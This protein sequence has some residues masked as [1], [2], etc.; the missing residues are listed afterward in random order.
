MKVKKL[1]TEL[2]KHKQEADVAFIDEESSP[3]PI[4]EVKAYGDKLVV[5]RE[6]AD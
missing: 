3:L 6:E 1:I 5:L 4:E 2:K